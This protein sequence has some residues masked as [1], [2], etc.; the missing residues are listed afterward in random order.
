MRP[1]GMFDV[2]LLISIVF[3]NQALA[4]T[5]GGAFANFTSGA[6]P[7]AMGSAFTAVADDV[8][9]LNWNSAGLSA[10]NQSQLSLFHTDLFN[11]GIN[12]NYLAVAIPRLWNGAFSLG[13]TQTDFQEALPYA[14]N[15]I[16]AAYA[17]SLGKNSVGLNFKALIAK[18]DFAETGILTK[19]RGFTIDVGLLRNAGKFNYGIV[20]N[21]LLSRLNWHTTYGETEE[22]LSEALKFSVS[23]GLS[24]KY[25]ST[26]LFAL[27]LEDLTDAK[28]VHCGFE[29]WLNKEK[30]VALRAGLVG[31]NPTF[32]L[33]LRKGALVFDWA[34]ATHSVSNNQLFSV[35]YDF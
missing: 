23:C 9:C 17:R 7:L 14:E 15:I 28:I 22:S 25:D 32:G 35:T 8:N 33:G 11:F 21:N 3:G 27:D 1:R 18:G 4:S 5:L 6:R 2:I 16:T 12:R 10:L 31:S 26:T 24:L 30:T 19:E 13:V 20:V 34:Y 29:R